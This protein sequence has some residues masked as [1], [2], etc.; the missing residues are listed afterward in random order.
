MSDH[1]INPT[2]VCQRAFAL[3]QSKQ[4]D[5]AEKLLANNLSKTAEDTAKGLYHSAFGVLCKLRS[6]YKE[7]WRHY[8]RA[9][10]LIPNDPALKIIVARLLIDQFAEYDSAIKRAKRVLE[11]IPENVVFAHQAY[12]TLGLAYIKKSN[13]KQAVAMLIKSSEKGFDGFVT[14]HNIDFHLVEAL[15]RKKWGRDECRHFIEKAHAFVQKTEETYLKE[16]F[17]RMLDAMQE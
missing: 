1:E 14:G 7:A 16:T 9:E 10:K 4:Y 13:K 15:L 3:M 11:I 12:T 8:Q 6:D 5:D 17:Q 2:E